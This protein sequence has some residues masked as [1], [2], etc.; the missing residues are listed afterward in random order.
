MPGHRPDFKH[1]FTKR[2]AI[3]LFFF[4]GTVFKVK[5]RMLTWSRMYS[6]KVSN[7]IRLSKVLF[8]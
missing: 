6:D 1:D 8:L 3:F 4:F 5:I 2:V 7:G